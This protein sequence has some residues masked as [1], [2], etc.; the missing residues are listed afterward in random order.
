M[1]LPKLKEWI[2][3]IDFKRLNP[4]TWEQKT[5]KSAMWSF[6]SVAFCFVLFVGGYFFSNTIH[7]LSNGTNTAS[8]DRG[9][10]E[11][12]CN[13]YGVELRGDLLTYIPKTDLNDSGDLALD[14]VSS[15]D[16][17]STLE[18]ADKDD[19]IKAILLEVDSS[20]GRPVAGEE[21]NE[22]VK[23][24]KKPVVAFIRSV[25]ASAA[26]LAA[27]GADQIFASKYSDVGSIGVT[28]SYLDN[29]GQNKSDG[30]SY[31]SLSSG[32]FKDAGSPDKG[33]TQEERI[34][35]MRDVNIMHQY[36]VKDVAENR[37]LDIEKVKKLADGSTMLGQ[38]ALE[39]G[40][41]DQIGG[42]EDAKNYLK[43]NI[44]EDV[45]VCW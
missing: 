19:R 4:N 6:I 35:F 22:A 27:S 3:K 40:L 18:G 9:E 29:V 39:N 32:K 23:N 37:K 43:E 21:I 17:L 24:S 36:F 14:E 8:E 30:L 25:G 31:N 11:K 28:M 41:I 16:I 44:G 34:L 13:V 2:A 45:E 26:Y 15:E 7:D 5:V 1:S 12:S 42:Y 10:S 20:G 38:A 33:L